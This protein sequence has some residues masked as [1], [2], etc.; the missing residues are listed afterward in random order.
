MKSLVTVAANAREAAAEMA[1][2][3]TETKRGALVAAAEA[4]VAGGSAFLTA[5]AVD[6]QVAAGAGTSPALMDRLKLT[7]PRIAAMAEGLRAVA[8]QPDPIGE[9]FE[10][11]SRPNGL[12]IT[13]VRVPIGVVAV[14]YEARPNV[15][16]DVAG[17]CIMSGNVALLR[18]SS[19][20]QF[21]NEAIA[22]ALR[23]A[24]ASAGVPIDA[25]QLVGDTSREAA[26]QLMQMKGSIDLLI[27]RGGAALIKAI[28]ENATVPFIIDGDGNCHVYVDKS[29][30]L[31]KATQ[32]VLNAKTQRPGVCNAA[33]TLLVH[34]DLVEAWL[35]S[36]LSDL[37]QAGV[38]VRGDETVR[39]AWPR[40]S[41]ATEEDWGTEFLDLIIAV[42][43]VDSIDDAITHVNRWGTSNAEA[44]IADDT[45]A[46][47]RF[48]QRVDA[49]SIF[50]NASTRFNDG[51][52][53]GFGSEI[54]IST[55]RLH[56]RG[57]MGLKELTTYRY[58]VWGDGQ[59][60]T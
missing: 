3:P 52:E 8:S 21:T 55:Q 57:P 11:W 5:N 12:K 18:G 27:P 37:S 15:T 46:A 42:K 49:G 14:I 13:K 4:I 58:V 45:D 23:E 20:A 54:G 6:L 28:E 48:T 33:E 16:A 51:S 43:V 19:H 30:D 32:I 9:V 41:E 47:L 34:R 60:R 59:I 36:I 35:P 40:A 17:L 25:V 26:I 1:L 38:E 10:E 56:A 50:V 7:V 29:A 44:I 39:K 24:I 2:L 53:F 22:N 31:V